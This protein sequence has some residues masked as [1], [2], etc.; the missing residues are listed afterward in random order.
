MVVPSALIVSFALVFAPVGIW[1]FLRFGTVGV[2][3]SLGLASLFF[4]CLFF[5]LV[6][7]SELQVLCRS[8]LTP[9]VVK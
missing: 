9:A 1:H 7:A 8:H 4:C 2:T 3:Y 5:E 6:F